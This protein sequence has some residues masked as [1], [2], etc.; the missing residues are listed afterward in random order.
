MDA[1]SVSW[2]RVRRSDV[3]RLIASASAG[4]GRLG[5]GEGRPGQRAK[6]QQQSRF[7]LLNPGPEITQKSSTECVCQGSRQRL[8][9]PGVTRGSQITEAAP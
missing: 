2:G 7:I 8:T 5:R 9:P 6:I 4:R 3:Q 1:H